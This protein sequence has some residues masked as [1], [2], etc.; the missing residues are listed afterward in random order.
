MAVNVYVTFLSIPPPICI[1]TFPY[2]P[3]NDAVFKQRTDV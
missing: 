3:T 2:R 1:G